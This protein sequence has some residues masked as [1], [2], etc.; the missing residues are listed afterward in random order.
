MSD[1]REFL[2]GAGLLGIASW[3]GGV[4]GQSVE[5]AETLQREAGAMQSIE[6]AENAITLENGELRLV[7]SATGSALSLIHKATGQECLAANVALPVFSVTQNRPYDNE[8]QLTLPAQTTSFPAE[9]VR[10]ENGK[11]LVDFAL[12]GYEASIDVKI[13]EAYIAFRLERLTYKGYTSLRPKKATPIDE[14]LF[15]QLPIRDRQNFGEWLNVMWDDKVAVNLL[16]TDPYVQIGAEQRQGFRLF[17]ARTV[18]EVQLE[19]VGAALIATSTERLLDC[20]ARVEEDFDLPRGVESRRRQEYR[21]SYYET[22]TITPANTEEHLRY[23]KMSGMRCMEI[24]YT[25]FA[26]SAGHFPWRPEYPGEMRDLRDVVGRIESAGIIPGIHIHYNKANKEDAYVTPRPDQRLNIRERFT[27]AAA[28][29]GSATEIPIESNPR[30]CTLDDER[31]ILKIQNELITYKSFTTRPPYRFLGCER[32]ALNTR[33]N[34]Y[35]VAASIGV[36]DVDTWPIFVRYT[37]DT[38]I[39]SEVADRLQ[40]IYGEAGFKFVY[41]DGAEDVPPPYWFN[42]SRAQWIVNQ[43]LDPKP[44]FAEGACK[45]HFSWH[46]LTRGNAFDVFRPEVMKAAT[47]AYPVAEAQRVAKD[48]TNIN[49]GW[50]GYW[51]PSADTIGTQPD[52]LEY[53]A[54]RA[55]GWDCPVSLIGDLEAMKAHPRTPDNLEALRRWEAFRLDQS[56]THEQRLCLRDLDQEHTLLREKNGELTLTPWAQIEDAA[57]KD[58]PCRAFVFERSG[59]IW[60]SYWHTSGE[61]SLRV[62]LDPRRCA[63]MREPGDSISIKS[64][65]GKMILPLGERRYLRYSGS[66]RDAVVSAFRNATVIST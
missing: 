22:S 39:Q 23:A 6:H 41:F 52:M 2:K 51:S 60:V 27:L 34:S 42:V 48:F 1:R 36:L 16:G 59:E 11:L 3:C 64:R 63:L 7:I 14:A 37:Q 65:D 13:T 19:D 28:I 18:A 15:I 17:Q 29:D 24:Y 33:P 30:L 66:A 46:I 45:S 38:S 62:A 47:R 31:R 40:A 54:S 56:F 32:G 53:V 5:S 10:Y 50:I 21:Y 25:A 55:A 43:K 57:G 49:F 9:R 26:K 35:E 61:A 44:L 20:V 4:S 12:V 58:R 8:L